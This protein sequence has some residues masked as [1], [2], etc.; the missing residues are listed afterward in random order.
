[1]PEL[2]YKSLAAKLIVGMPFKVLVT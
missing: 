2:L 1:T